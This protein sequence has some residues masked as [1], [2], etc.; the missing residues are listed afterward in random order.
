MI[1]SLKENGLEQSN[2]IVDDAALTEVIRRY[3]RESGVRNLERAIA[4]LCRKAAVEVVDK[5]KEHKV[6]IVQDKVVKFLGQPQY[7]FGKQEE[8]NQVGTV[9]GLAWTEKGGELLVIE[10]TI[11]PGKGRLQI[12]GKL[13]DVMQES[14]K[15]ALSYV[16]SLDAAFRLA[17]ISTI[18]S[19]FISMYRR[20]RFRR[21]VRLPVLRWQHCLF[22]R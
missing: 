1:S 3:T 14:A 10:T 20:A 19:I 4:T 15:A 21:T 2:L 6:T 7:R 5:G 9:T 22:P 17:D 12:T 11:L 8:T 13:G 18:R 16:R